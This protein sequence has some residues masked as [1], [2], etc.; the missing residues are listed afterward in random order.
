MRKVSSPMPL[1][2]TP[3]EYILAR[4]NLLPVPLFDAPLAPGIA[5]IVIT[6]CELGLFD[7]LNKG[8]LPLDVLAERVECHP[9]GLQLML[10]LLVS[11]GYLRYRRGCYSNTRMARRWL[12]AT[13]PTNIAPYIVHSQDI[14][15]IWDHVAEVV[16]TNA[17]AMCMPYEE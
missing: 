10:Q 5:K 12:T 11:A 8:A 15:A 2:L 14:V 13:S 4:L 17:Q 6:G 1:R 7:A 9:Q 3:F 16:R